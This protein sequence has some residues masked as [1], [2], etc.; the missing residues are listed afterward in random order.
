MKAGRRNA[1]KAGWIALVPLAAAVLNA[2]CAADVP[3]QIASNK[4]LRDQVMGAIAGDG[5]LAE[6]MT[7]RLLATDSLRARVIE[8]VLQDS[9]GAR[10]VI[11]RVG[12]NPEALDYVLQAASADS[13]GR[14]HLMTL[15]KGMQ[16][17]L[18]AKR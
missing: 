5:A 9:N 8:T 16:M 4:Q 12:H 3:K 11:A 6:E 2:G 10:Y 7:K 13:A 14:A 15:F 1:S 17:A 18:Q